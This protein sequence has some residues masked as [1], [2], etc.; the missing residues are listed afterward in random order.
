V[1]AEGPVR[2]PAQ[3]PDIAAAANSSF[4]P[5]GAR[6]RMR[7]RPSGRCAWRACS[8][9]GFR[10]KRCR[11]FPRRSASCVGR[12]RL[13]T[14]RRTRSRDHHGNTSAAPQPLCATARRSSVDPVARERRGPLVP[15]SILKLPSPPAPTAIAKKKFSP[16]AA[17]HSCGRRRGPVPVRPGQ[18]I[19]RSPECRHPADSR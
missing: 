15:R 3:S 2:V 14:A 16:A 6:H 12:L 13:A 11:S 19:E 8:R 1:L 4:D 7:A 17:P 10:T 9:G 18:R 5:A